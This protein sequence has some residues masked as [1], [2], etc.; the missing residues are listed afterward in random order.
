M[1]A[2]S[3][4]LNG[5]LGSSWNDAD[6]TSDEGVSVYS[7]SDVASEVDLGESDKEVAQGQQD[8]TTE[9]HSR[10]RRAQPSPSTP[11]IP[12]HGTPAKTSANKVTARQSQTLSSPRNTPRPVKG[13]RTMPG[14]ERY[15]QNF[16]MP[17]INPP[18]GYL[19]GSPTRNSQARQRKL[20]QSTSHDV[21][22]SSPRFSSRKPT[23]N[24]LRSH[25]L[26]KEEELGPWHYINL[27]SEH[28]ALPLVAYVLNVFSYSM[29]HIVKPFLGVAV[30][31]GILLL[32]LQLATGMLRSTLSNALTPVCIIP[33]SSYIIPLCATTP[34]E[35]HQANFEELI[36]VQTRFEDVLD[37]SKDTTELPSTIKNSELA[38]RDLRTLVQFSK[39]PSRQELGNEFDYFIQTASQASMDLSRYNS[40]I[41]AAMDRVIATNTWT[42]AVLKGIEE[43]DASVGAV[44]R[45]FNA[46]TG[47][48]IAAPP[49][50]QERIFDQYILHVSKNKE[51]ITRLIETAQALLGVLNNLDERL[52]T[53]YAIAV[54]D[55]H[56]ITKNQEELLSSLWTK[57]GR[58]RDNVKANN[59][60]LDLLKNISA[61]RKKALIHVS[62][63]LLKLQEIQ[64]EL[65][66]LR[67]G[68]AAP[69]VLGH[70]D[71][72]PL[73]FHL[74]LIEKGVE[75]LR[76]ARGES[77]RVEGDNYRKMM[78]SSEDGEEGGVKELPPGKSVPTISVKAR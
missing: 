51:E 8:V 2:R 42:M 18:N 32:A 38:I 29:R 62:E 22:S 70:R 7:A 64:A 12:P 44:G 4:R 6:Y 33:G 35:N 37:A 72:L 28:V 78:R 24:E 46:M 13:M 3:P 53:I 54:N 56:T 14:Q 66:N 43:K 36:N 52:G 9:R 59:K 74:D 39:L 41:G 55:D 16:I 67:E 11:L 49:T 69:E 77:M 65:E 19:D 57:L 10:T 31:I 17:S 48:F 68:V 27:F 20:R 5:S 71:E 47:A 15:E 75:R 58:N 26:D 61:Y 73:T 76:V 1:S 50:L 40:R 34:Y 63:T 60:Q 21:P 45:V 25:S 30:G 23:K